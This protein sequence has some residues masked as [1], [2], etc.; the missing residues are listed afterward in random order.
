MDP[1][2]IGAA[3]KTVEEDLIP[4]FIA[5]V[6]ACQGYWMANRASG[7]VLVLTCWTGAEQ[8]EAA[9]ASDG[10]Q[11]TLAM[12]RVGLRVH[13]VQEL[14][15]IGVE[16][17]HDSV[18]PVVR[19]ARATWVERLGGDRASSPAGMHREAVRMQAASRGFCAS[20]WLADAETGNGL[21]LSLW[22]ELE[23]LQDGEDRSQRRRQWLERT[24]DCKVDH[25]SEYEAI[26]VVAPTTASIDLTDVSIGT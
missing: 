22:A 11:R 2:R 20:Y 23:D 8:L 19:F 21:G 10:E 4:S 24:L 3:V 9:R 18:Q 14:A 17:S 25:V 16:E 13:A 1:A 26:G 12:E 7:D 15:V 5:H 6:G